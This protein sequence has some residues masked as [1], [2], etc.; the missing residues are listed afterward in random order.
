MDTSPRCAGLRKKPGGGRTGR[1]PCDTPPPTCVKSCCK[2]VELK[3]PLPLSRPAQLSLRQAAVFIFAV[4]ALSEVS[5]QPAMF[6]ASVLTEWSVMIARPQEPACLCLLRRHT[7]DTQRLS[8]FL[9][10]DMSN[11]DHTLVM[12]ES[13]PGDGTGPVEGENF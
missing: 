6:A 9:P 11:G 1:K 13:F 8:C 3:R 12:E 10:T 2:S 7:G 4:A 5:L